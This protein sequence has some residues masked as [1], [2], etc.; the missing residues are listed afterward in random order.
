MTQGPETGREAESCVQMTSAGR[1]GGRGPAPGNGGLA[2]GPA[3]DRARRGGRGAGAGTPG[4]DAGNHE[5]C[6]P[7]RPPRTQAPEPGPAF[8][9]QGAGSTRLQRRRAPPRSGGSRIHPAACLHFNY[10]R[11]NIHEPGLEGDRGL[12][13]PSPALPPPHPSSWAESWAFFFPFPTPLAPTVGAQQIWG[14]GV[15]CEHECERV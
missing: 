2:G 12:S 8:R 6:P 11:I 9:R 15:V 13:F 14:S 10:R 4:R 7:S 1:E 5:K 3:R